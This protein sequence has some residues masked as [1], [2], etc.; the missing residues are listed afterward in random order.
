MTFYE[1]L[2]AKFENH[3]F[4]VPSAQPSLTSLFGMRRGENPLHFVL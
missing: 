2:L 4:T 3:L 1:N